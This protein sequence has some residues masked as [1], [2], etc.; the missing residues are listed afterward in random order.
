MKKLLLTFSAAALLFSCSVESKKEKTE[1][2]FSDIFAKVKEEFAP[3]RRA[4]TF[5]AKLDVSEKGETIVLRGS[6]TEP[7]ARA[8]LVTKLTEAG[9]DV[10]DSM[11]NL[12]H[13]ALGDKIYGVTNQSVINFRYSPSYSSESATQTVMGAPLQILEKRGG[14]TRA[15]TPEGYIAWVSSGSIAYMNLEQFNDWRAAKKVI[16]TS[17]YTLYRAGAS[18]RSDVVA[19]GVMGN[20]VKFIATAGPYVK[21]ELPD[22]RVAFVLTSHTADFSRWLSSRNPSPENILTTAREF[23][24]FPYMW[25]GT[26][27]KAMD[28][29]GFT[30]TVY[31]LNG[32]ILERDASQQAKTGEDVEL[33]D[34]FG[35]LKA[36]DL[37]FFGSKA[38]ENRSERI[39]HVGIYMANGEFIHAATSVRINS[40]LPDAANYYEG[41]TRL[42]R[43]RRIL[44]MI[45][46]DPD[47]ISVSKHPWYVAN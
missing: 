12:P 18:E 40:L 9:I 6:T 34:D 47:I 35:N 43:A 27:I 11:I 31:F 8:T 29:S 19:D 2:Q 46:K 5:E 16:I 14:W 25:G 45:D 33:T 13:P 39:T 22:G 37:L 17:H 10:L 30:K 26:S 1:S 7:E 21:V 28:C 36:G 23:V 41:S 44:T 15:I 24:G 3:D 20:I 42:V 4:K 32:V 38:T